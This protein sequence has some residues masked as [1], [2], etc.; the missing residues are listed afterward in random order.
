M[1]LML[2]FTTLLWLAIAIKFWYQ[3]RL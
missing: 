2:I 1:T 3:A